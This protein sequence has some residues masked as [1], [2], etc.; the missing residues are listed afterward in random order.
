MAYS[1]F[2]TLTGTKRSNLKELRVQHRGDPWRILFAFDPKRKAVILLGG[3]KAGNKN[4]YKENMP[5][6]E[7]RFKEHLQAIRKEERT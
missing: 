7:K 4:W 1:L 3:N 5:I 2:D 6:A